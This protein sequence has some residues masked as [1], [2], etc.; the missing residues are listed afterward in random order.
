MTL[1]RGR[2]R[3]VLVE[4]NP[5]ARREFVELLLRCGVVVAPFADA[6]VAFLF[7]LG[8]LEEIDGVLVNE[9]DDMPSWLR[10]RLDLLPAG[11]PVVAYSG[12][13]PKREARITGGPLPIESHAAQ[14]ALSLAE[15]QFEQLL[16]AEVGAKG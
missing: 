3:V 9:D 6:R 12:R 1:G 2:M 11:P 5:D 10:R 15:K 7:L 8:K 13:H 14:E 4:P 16:A